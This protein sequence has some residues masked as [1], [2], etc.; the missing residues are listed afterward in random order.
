MREAKCYLFFCFFTAILS[1]LDA[2]DLSYDVQLLSIGF[3][4]AM[5]RPPNT[6]IT[7]WSQVPRRETFRS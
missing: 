7:N 6:Q 1:S 4:V 3:L 5:L 2:N